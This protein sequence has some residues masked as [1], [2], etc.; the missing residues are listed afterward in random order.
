MLVYIPR[1]LSSGP[2]PDGL[3]DSAE[4]YF[5][6]R[7]GRSVEGLRRTLSDAWSGTGDQRWSLALDGMETVGFACGTREGDGLRVNML[8]MTGRHNNADSGITLLNR[9]VHGENRALAS[10]AI[11]SPPAGELGPAQHGA[12]WSLVPRDRK[13]LLLPA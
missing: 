11:L 4:R 2:P 7:L 9:L 5:G 1:E 10:G 6:A 8:Y 3:F 13:G 12:G